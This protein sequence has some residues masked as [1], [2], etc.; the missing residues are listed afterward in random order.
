VH[1]VRYPTKKGMKK[2][3]KKRRKKRK[4]NQSIIW[5]KVIVKV[6]TK[7]V[8]RLHPEGR[9][10]GKRRDKIMNQIVWS[11]GCF[12]IIINRGLSLLSRVE[13]CIFY[14]R[15]KQRRSDKKGNYGTFRPVSASLDLGSFP[16][17]V[18]FLTFPSRLLVGLSHP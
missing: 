4:G 9:R 8:T 11:F 2:T 18:S 14:V 5:G 15:V 3:K 17:L 6:S 13:S 12:A 7:L 1:G 16:L 10:G